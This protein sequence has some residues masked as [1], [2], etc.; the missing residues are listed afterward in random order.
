M[1]RMRALLPLQHGHRSRDDRAYEGQHKR[2][3]RRHC[4][5]PGKSAHSDTWRLTASADRAQRRFAD[6]QNRVNAL[7]LNVV[8]PGTR[9]ETRRRARSSD[10]FLSGETANW[11]HSIEKEIPSGK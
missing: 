9:V 1:N 4:R 8:P 6:L 5:R 2:P 10:R 11:R 3:G 7:I